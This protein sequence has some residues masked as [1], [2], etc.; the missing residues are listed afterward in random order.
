MME[1]EMREDIQVVN[2]SYLEYDKLTIL[3]PVLM[4]LCLS[5]TI[6]EYVFSA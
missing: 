5:R 3:M 2:L 4:T 6:S 1:V